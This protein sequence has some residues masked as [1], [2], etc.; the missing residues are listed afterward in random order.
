[1]SG[2]FP[3]KPFPSGHNCPHRTRGGI[4][5]QPSPNTPG[6]NIVMAQNLAR[7]GGKPNIEPIGDI[8]DLPQGVKWGKPGY[9]KGITHEEW[10][11][12]NPT[13][14][15]QAELIKHAREERDNGTTPAFDL[16]FDD[17]HQ[18]RKQDDAVTAKILQPLPSVE[19]VQMMQEQEE[20]VRDYAKEEKWG[21]WS[22]EVKESLADAWYGS[23]KPISDAWYGSS[24]RQAASPAA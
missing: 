18:K 8:R 23:S 15:N 24:K 14:E 9:E 22:S 17:L 1:M 2:P 20:F 13:V 7:V 11:K 16:M 3:V 12:K 6:Q 10:A 21:S 5:Y 19:Q 4:A